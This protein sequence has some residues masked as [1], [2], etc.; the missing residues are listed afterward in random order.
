MVRSHEAEEKTRFVDRLGRAIHYSRFYLLTL[1]GVFVVA[2]VA[3]FVFSEVNENAREKA[4]VLAEEAEQRYEM[5]QSTEDEA[6]RQEIEESLLEDL[7]FIID[8]YP[9]QY[10][11]QRAYFISGNLYYEKELWEEASSRLLE[12]PGRFPKSYLAEE[13]LFISAI[14]HEEL[15][16]PDEALT[17]YRRLT[18]DYPQSPRMPHALFSQ[19]RILESRGDAEEAIQIYNTLRLDYSFSNWT[20]LAVSRIIQL[21]SE[22]QESEE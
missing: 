2:V 18:E 7:A 5:W 3:Y 22:E 20:K 16:E 17:L 14:C 21:E 1:L 6:G 10:A 11:A 8:E 9:R 4:T 19:G 12:I 13:A 15:G